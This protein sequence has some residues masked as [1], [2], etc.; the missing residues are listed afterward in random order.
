MNIVVQS[1]SSAI[2][3]R[4]CD[5]SECKNEA[6]LSVMDVGSGMTQLFLCIPHV[7]I[8]IE[9]KLENEAFALAIE[10]EVQSS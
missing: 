6:I 7:R 2:G 8:W 1:I 5:I 3:F 4:V 9:H 10:S